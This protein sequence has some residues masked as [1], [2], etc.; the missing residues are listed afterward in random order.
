MPT[1]VRYNLLLKPLVKCLVLC[2]IYVIATDANAGSGDIVLYASRARVRTGSWTVVADS[3]AAGGH[4]MTTPNR[5][6]PA[7]KIPL[8]HPREYFELTFHALAGKPYHLWVRGKAAND[9]KS[10]DSAY[11]QFSDSV[12]RWGSAIARIGTTSAAAVMLQP[13]TVQPDHDW[14]W[15]NNGWCHLGGNFY[16]QNTGMHTIRVQVLEDGFSIDQIVL[17]PSTYLGA[18]PGKGADDTT[19]LAA[20]PAL[21]STPPKVSIG[22]NPA[23]GA[24]PLNVTFSAHVSLTV[25][26]ITSYKWTFG[27]GKTSSDALPSHLYQNPGSYNVKLTVSDNLGNVVSAAALVQA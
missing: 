7:I 8:T 18:A 21:P 22:L 14:G 12:T 24:A 2:S 25:G 5:G 6:A 10:N 3:S 17:S 26:F 20:S 15:T 16:F 11:F 1:L 23:S 19:I 4:A 13:C 27:D 9:S